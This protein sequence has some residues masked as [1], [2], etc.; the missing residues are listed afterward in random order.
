ML[1][2]SGLIDLRSHDLDPAY[3]FPRTAQRPLRGGARARRPEPLAFRQGDGLEV[4]EGGA[5]SARDLRLTG[6]CQP[7]LLEGELN[8][9]G[10]PRKLVDI[11][12]RS[13]AD[14]PT[15][16][17]EALHRIHDCMRQLAW[18]P[19]PTGRHTDASGQLRLVVPVRRAHDRE[20]ASLADPQG[21][22]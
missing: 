13:V 20:I 21:L 2:A 11:A 6:A 5:Q 15:T 17:V 22:G 19:F 7:H 4:F 3:G 1:R 12:V 16:T 14:D 18:R 9:A 8:V 10:Q